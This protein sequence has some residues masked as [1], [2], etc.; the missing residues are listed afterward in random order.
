MREKIDLIVTA[1]P[2]AIVAIDSP[3]QPRGD[4]FRADF[5]AVRIANDAEEV[6]G[7]GRDLQ[8]WSL[9]KSSE[10]NTALSGLVGFDFARAVVPRR[11]SGAE[12]EWERPTQEFHERAEAYFEFLQLQLS[13]PFRM[14]D[15]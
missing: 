13:G 9:R 1:K 15:E 4:E 11:K 12:N 8:M 14:M 3:A 2:T 7:F 10:A 6:G 5:V